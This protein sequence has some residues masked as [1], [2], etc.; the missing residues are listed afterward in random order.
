MQKASIDPS[1]NT[2]YKFQLNYKAVIPHV[3]RMRKHKYS[4]K[5][6][7]TYKTTSMKLFSRFK[8]LKKIEC[9]SSALRKRSKQLFLVL[10]SCSKILSSKNLINSASRELTLYPNLNSRTIFDK[11]SFSEY[12]FNKRSRVICI[13]VNNIAK[14][15]PKY[16]KIGIRT[17]LQRLSQALSYSNVPKTL[18]LIIN[19]INHLEEA[20]EKFREIISLPC[21]SRVYISVQYYY[22]IYEKM[23]L[24]WLN[25]HSPVLDKVTGITISEAA[26]SF[27]ALFETILDNPD[28]FRNLQKL[29]NLRL[30]SDDVT[31]LGL[32][33]L[34]NLNELSLSLGF[35]FTTCESL[36]G[37]FSL[38]LNTKNMT[39]NLKFL[40]PYDSII[41]QKGA[42]ENFLQAWKG[43]RLEQLLLNYLS[44][45]DQKTAN[46]VTLN[47]LKSLAGAK[48]LRILAQASSA[49]FSSWK[50]QVN[51]DEIS[52]LFSA[53]ELKPSSLIIKAEQISFESSKIKSGEGLCSL[54]KLEL[55]GKIMNWTNMCKWLS[56]LRTKKYFEFV[57]SS[58]H[59][60]L[61]DCKDLGLFLIELPTHFNSR[62]VLNTPEISCEAFLQLLNDLPGY[63]NTLL[64]L[65]VES[66]TIMTLD[67]NAIKNSLQRKQ[68]LNFELFVGTRRLFVYKNFTFCEMRV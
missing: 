37:K 43:K 19:F 1:T 20:L 52:A 48:E 47:V 7:Y 54:E 6:T 55:N 59:Q 41:K 11:R 5:M 63:K 18:F 33:T 2:L 3:E 56:L 36:L 35:N 44:L 22:G 23:D 29:E 67:F 31:H 51:L 14:D 30:L 38:P 49:N 24:S 9:N 50:F 57:F 25:N 58:Q 15:I 42:Y 10:Q 13:E 53:W 12:K 28:L 32:N 68:K 46:S 4:Y 21:V 40:V 39:L 8:Y 17:Y 64:I 45:E 60:N 66:D 16:Y 61:S 34:Q 62:L 65:K 26:D 27:N